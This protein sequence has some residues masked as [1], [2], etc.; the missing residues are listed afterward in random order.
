MINIIVFSGYIL[1]LLGVGLGVAGKQKTTEQFFLGS[2][3]LP[4]LAVAMSMYASVTSAVTFMG[5]PT[6][7]Y[8]DNI[9]LVVICIVSPLLAPILMKLFYRVYHSLQV[10][11]SYEYLEIRFSALG[12]RVVSLLFLLARLGWMGTVVYAP[13]L[14]LSTATSLELWQAIVIIGLFS[15][16]YTALGGISAVVWTDVLQYLLMV[17]G[18][19]WVI[20]TLLGMI[21]GSYHG[22]LAIA[23]EAH[24]LSIVSFRPSLAQMSAGLIFVTFFFQMMYDYGVDQVTVQR[25]QSIGNQKGIYRAILFNAATDFFIIA[26]LL[27]CGLCLYAFYTFGAHA[28]PETISGDKILPYFIITELPAGISGLLFAGLFAAAMSSIDSGIN[29]M[30]TVI[31]HDLVRPLSKR[32]DEKRDLILARV[33]TVLFGLLA[34]AI[35]FFVARVESIIETYMRIVALFSAPVLGLFVL[36]LISRRANIGGWLI[37]AAVAWGV[38][39]AQQQGWILAEMEIH[40]MY[41][42]PISF[43]LTFIIGYVSSFFTSKTI[44]TSATIWDQWR[45]QKNIG[46][47]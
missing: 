46:Q 47:S 34:T 31:I 45:Y 43:L 24:K 5:L 1:L 26:L 42:F 23:E 9:S 37:G 39:L 3:R 11:T 30:S 6:M 12:R 27:F 18:L 41:N 4:W 14:A 28:L 29:S 19:I 44:N 35:A 10:T 2:R 7:A 38:A 25:L 22:V 16:L 13:S 17:G 20:A 40:Y 15:T 8:N 32:T 36:G 33:L 21:P